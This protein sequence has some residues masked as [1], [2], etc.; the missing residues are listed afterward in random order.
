MKFQ[1]VPVVLSLG[2]AFLFA[3]NASAQIRFNVDVVFDGINTPPVNATPPWLMATFEEVSASQ[4]LF[5]LEATGNLTDPENIS[6]FYFNFDDSLDLGSLSYTHLGSAGSFALPAWVFGENSLKADGDGKYDIRLD[7]SPG[8]TT[9]LTFNRHE[10]VTYLLSYSGPET[11]HEES[12][13]F[14]S[15]PA[16]GNGP[17][18]VAA[19]VQNT[20][21]GGSAWLAATA[22]ACTAI[23]EPTGFSLLGLSGMV[24]LARYLRKLHA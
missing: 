11:I 22:T 4:I 24:A 5:T 13:D 17:F 23:P 8:A 2:G 6:Q 19:H 21:S 7:F 9:S 18:L 3:C 15:M 10:S 16:G 20:I 1:V 14:L 12:F